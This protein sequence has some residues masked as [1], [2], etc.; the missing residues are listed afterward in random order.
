MKKIY[1][2]KKMFIFMNSFSLFFVLIGLCGGFT[3]D[4]SMFYLLFISLGLSIISLLFLINKICYNAEEIRFLFIYRRVTF[5]YK[6]IKEV[7]VQY[8][9]ISG[10]KVIFNFE[11]ET[12]GSCYDYL[13]YTRKLKKENIRNTI[14]FIGG[15]KKEIEELLDKCH[16]SKKG[17]DF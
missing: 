17:L 2:Q 14:Y 5:K 8:D 7:F 9:L 4:K 6:D 10:M 12:D 11:K 13:E 1:A 16:C 15:T 3:T